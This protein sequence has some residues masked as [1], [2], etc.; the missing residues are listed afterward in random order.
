MAG[1]RIGIDRELEA[2]FREFAQALGLADIRSEPSSAAGGLEIAL[3]DLHGL[4]VSSQFVWGAVLG[5]A[6]S[7]S[8]F[9]EVFYKGTRMQPSKDDLRKLEKLVKTATNL[10][11][12]SR[13]KKKAVTRKSAAK[14]KK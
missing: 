11:P 1:I 6:V 14:R 2:D 8:K 4:H 13:G 10:L 12:K 3:F 5:W 9:F 7:R